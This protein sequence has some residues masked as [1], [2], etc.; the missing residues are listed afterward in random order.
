MVHRD[1]GDEVFKSKNKSKLGDS[2]RRGARRFHIGFHGPRAPGPRIHPNFV[3][4]KSRH[5]G[6]PLFSPLSDFSQSPPF[7]SH[8]RQRNRGAT[9]QHFSVSGRA[10]Q[11][12]Q[13]GGLESESNA[14]YHRESFEHQRTLPQTNPFHANLQHGHPRSP[15]NVPLHPGSLGQGTGGSLTSA[16]EIIPADDRPTTFIEQQPA[17]FQSPNQEVLRPQQLHVTS[18]LVDVQHPLHREHPTIASAVIA[19]SKDSDQ[20]LNDNLVDVDGSYAFNAE[21]QSQPDLVSALGFFDTISQASNIGE[22]QGQKKVVSPGFKPGVLER[23]FRPIIPTKHRISRRDLS[24]D[25]T[26]ARVASNSAN[27][28]RNSIV[29]D[30]RLLSS[31]FPDAPSDLLKFQSGSLTN[32]HIR[33]TKLLASP[34]SSTVESKPLSA[35]QDLS[36]NLSNTVAIPSK[37]QM[38][39]SKKTLQSNSS[40]TDLALAGSRR[41]TAY[42]PHYSNYKGRQGYRNY[43]TH[44]DPYQR[45]LPNEDQNDPYYRLVNRPT[46]SRRYFPHVCCE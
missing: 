12:K 33:N 46:T 43:R 2:N 10:P 39:P 27:A 18:K 38:L 5:G 26:I 16:T 32:D 24:D 34:G 42:E 28:G 9:R 44:Q 45:Y 19:H 20:R 41:R 37:L 6:A 22:S 8:H 40:S 35:S 13:N 7:G 17:P 25:A 31:V 4:Q 14:H 23:G 30:A 21:K 11:H 29:N 15:Q 36:S 3:S 1:M